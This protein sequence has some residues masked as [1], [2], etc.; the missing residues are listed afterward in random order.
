M[1]RDFELVR[2]LLIEL[3]GEDSVDLSPYTKEQVNYHKALIKE[4][5][6]AEGTIHYPS[7]HQTDVPD[8]AMLKRLTWEGHEFLD[9]AKND[10]VWNK[11]KAIIKDKG[12]SLSLDALK[13]ALAE[14][15]K[16]LMS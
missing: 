3:E 13:I 15:V 6:F 7:T 5:G 10:T 16:M 8:L 4:A 2:K 9:K 14:A 11:A 12:V 1:K